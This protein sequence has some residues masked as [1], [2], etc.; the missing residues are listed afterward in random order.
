M[1]RRWVCSLDCHARLLVA[2]AVVVRV[3]V[4][5]TDRQWAG[6]LVRT[7]GAAAVVRAEAELPNLENR[8]MV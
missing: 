1:H 3:L 2:D 7:A 5:E 8:R 4:C 6:V